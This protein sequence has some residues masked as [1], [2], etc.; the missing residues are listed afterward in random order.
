MNIEEKIEKNIELTTKNAERLYL[1]ERYSRAAK[2]LDNNGFT[3]CTEYEGSRYNLFLRI[4]PISGAAAM[5]V[6]C[7]IVC[8]KEAR[9]MISEYIAQINCHL[10][11]QKFQLNDTGEIYVC[12]E[13]SLEKSHLGISDLLYMEVSSIKLLIAFSG[14]LNKLAHL[15]LIT[16]EETN[17]KQLIENSLTID[18]YEFDDIEYM[19]DFDEEE[20]EKEETEEAKPSYRKICRPRKKLREFLDSDDDLI[21]PTSITS[22]DE[23]KEK[24]S[25]SFDKFIDELFSDDT[26][27]DEEIRKYCRDKP[28]SSDSTAEKVN[29]MNLIME[30][31]QENK[32]AKSAQ[33]DEDGDDD[34]TKDD[35]Q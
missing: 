24:S 26:K 7:G 15:R 19:F 12:S 21:V 10:S 8:L 32:D 11:E 35:N 1:G 31:V 9:T 29:L 14:V 20:E 6:G 2:F 4:F 28:N 5:E 18:L 27:L 33:D 25:D 16:D 17:V 23:P 34:D 3:V 30:E 22:T 13:A